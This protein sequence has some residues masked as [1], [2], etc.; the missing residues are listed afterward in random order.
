MG[1]QLCFFFV[2][3]LCDLFFVVLSP[4]FE[5]LC[6]I[7]KMGSSSSFGAPSRTMY[8]R[9]WAIMGGQDENYGKSTLFLLCYY[10][11]WLRLMI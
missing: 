1:N 5:K 9:L 3:I 4:G 10:P 11:L 8:D 2:T 7:L 6:A